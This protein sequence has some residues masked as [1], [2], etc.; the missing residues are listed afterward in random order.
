MKSVVSICISLESSEIA[1]TCILLN[2]NKCKVVAYDG[3][4]IVK[5]GKTYHFYKREFPYSDGKKET[6]F[7][8]EDGEN[9]EDSSQQWHDEFC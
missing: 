7:Y 4:T 3:E 1:K 9:L 8:I 5:N 2:G 6:L